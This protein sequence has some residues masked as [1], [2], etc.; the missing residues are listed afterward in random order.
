MPVQANKDLVRAMI[1]QVWNA[2]RAD[3]LP[4]FWVEETRDVAE[5]LHQ[6]LT[7]AFPDLH[8]QIEDMV[9]EADRVVIRLTFEGTHSG[10]FRGIEPT[11]RRVRFGAIRIYRLTGGKVAETWAYQDALGLLQQ[12]RA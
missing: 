8:V 1:D 5:G 4:E 9:A 11:G 10:P 2:G 6:I 12:L 3:R 7:A